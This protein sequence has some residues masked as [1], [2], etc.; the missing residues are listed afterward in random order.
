MAVELAKLS[1]WLATMQLGQPLSF[2]DHHLK[3]GNSLL[4]AN[5]DE[6]EALLKQDDFSKPTAQSVVAEAKGQ[7]MLV[8]QVRPLQ[9]K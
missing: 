3:Q 7:Y 2:L 4:G 9:Q 8:N 5:L 1:L 6:I